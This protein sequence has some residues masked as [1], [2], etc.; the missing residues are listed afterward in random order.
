[1]AN[2]YD[3]SYNQNKRILEIRDAQTNK[4]LFVP[5]VASGAVEDWQ[6]T[7]NTDGSTKIQYNIGNKHFEHFVQGEMYSTLITNYKP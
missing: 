1:M 2:Q 5:K 7:L 4:V 6:T 3:Y